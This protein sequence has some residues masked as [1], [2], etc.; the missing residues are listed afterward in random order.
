MEGSWKKMLASLARSAEDDREKVRKL[1]ES[2]SFLG[3]LR[4]EE[5]FQ[6]PILSAPDHFSLEFSKKQN[7]P[8]SFLLFIGQEYLLEANTSKSQLNWMIDFFSSL[9]F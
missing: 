7:V 6:F 4:I 2:F 5:S 3:L 1:F 9:L 8:F